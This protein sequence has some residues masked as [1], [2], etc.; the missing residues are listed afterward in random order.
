MSALFTARCCEPRSTI[1]TRQ[2]VYRAALL[3]ALVALVSACSTAP[4]APQRS[5]PLPPEAPQLSA[6]ERWATRLSAIAS[7]QA[8]RVRGKVAYRLPDDAGSASLDWQQA[9]QQSELRLSGPL[10]V[11]STEIHNEGAL[12]RVKREG[13]ERLYPADAAPWL[14]GGTLLPV[15]ID[16]IQHW[17]LGVPDPAQPVTLLD[18][19]N[20]LAN[21][22]EQN[23]WV[24]RY[25]EYRD[26]Q[27]LALPTRLLLEV[28]KIKLS[29][30]VILRAWEL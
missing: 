1:Q 20:A 19:D 15:P 16:S 12:L 30:K 9:E 8:W 6:Q 7:M 17:L 4:A 13:I 3:A 2:T 21:R 27:G 24:I 23:G 29:L 25:D 18:T 10:G 28:P 22:I 11:G 5:A 26:V 14:P